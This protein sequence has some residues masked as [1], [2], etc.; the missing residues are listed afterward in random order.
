[1]PTLHPQIVS[2]LEAMEKLAL[3]PIEAMSP[4]EARAQM[5]PTS[6]SRKAER[7][8]VA[9]GRNVTGMAAL[10]RV[11]TVIGVVAVVENSL[12]F[13]PEKDK[14]LTVIVTPPLLLTV[15]D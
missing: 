15:T 4:A 9:L 13:G 12:A 5:E 6:Q 2:A 11:V 1:M 14:P 10:A 8:P 3:R 7:L